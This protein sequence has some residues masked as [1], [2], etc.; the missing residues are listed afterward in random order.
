M[1]SLGHLIDRVQWKDKNKNPSR[2]DYVREVAN[3]VYEDL[4][5]RHTWHWRR[6]VGQIA[7]VPDY[8]AGTVS[9]SGTTVTGASTTFTADMVGSHIRVG[10]DVRD[11]LITGFTSTTSLTIADPYEQTASCLLYTSDA[12]DE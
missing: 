1:I 7:T 4:W 8:T 11:Y 3:E 10:T 5:G 2:R 6:T 9:I 12:A